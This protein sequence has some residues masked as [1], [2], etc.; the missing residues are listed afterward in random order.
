MEL[1]KV[2]GIGFHKTG[3]TS[4]HTAL[5]QLGYSSIHGDPSQAPFL[6]DEGRTLIKLIDA[7]NYSLPTIEKYDAFTDNP[8]FSIW[9][10]LDIHYPNSKFILT[11]REE[12]EWIASCVNFFGGRRV[13]PMRKWMFGEYGDPSSSDRAKEI[14]LKAYRKHNADII[15]YFKS[16][17]DDLLILKITEGEGW[18]KLCFFLK[19]QIPDVT[20]PLKN[21]TKETKLTT[22]IS[23]RPSISQT[24]KKKIRSFFSR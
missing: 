8:Y 5:I 14:W 2:F 19:K 21:K 3:T 9:K 15:N 17:P 22:N 24:V 16:R 12:N 1:K 6:G 23:Y 13:R 20:F 18:E 4:L 7:G 11:I 10:E